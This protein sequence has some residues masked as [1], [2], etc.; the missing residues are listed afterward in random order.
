MRGLVTAAG[1]PARGATVKFK[2]EDGSEPYMRVTDVDGR[3]TPVTAKPGKYTLHAELAG[4]RP[5]ETAVTVSEG[6]DQEIV[7]ALNP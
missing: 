5:G 4:V 6:S 7:I 2:R 3:F 1:N